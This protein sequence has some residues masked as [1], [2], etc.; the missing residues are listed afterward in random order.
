M[1]NIC[2][3]IV[4][5]LSIGVFVYKH[6]RSLEI[7]RKIT[8]NETMLLNNKIYNEVIELAKKNAPEFYVKFTT[9]YPSFDP[10]LKKINPELKR[11]E[12]IF[13][14]LLKLNFSSKE[15]AIIAGVLHTTIQKR[16]NKIR[17]RLGIPSNV[18]I[19]NFFED[20]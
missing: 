7:K 5:I 19:Y 11:S 13:C 18:N 20:L 10:N 3:I 2:L 6:F 4:F 1:L 8:E 12:L 17:K 9:L 16:K 15:I 14:A